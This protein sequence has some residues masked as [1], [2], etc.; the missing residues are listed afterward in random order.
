MATDVLTLPLAL[1]DS[2]PL[3]NIHFPSILRCVWTSD[4]EQVIPLG[5]M[6]FDDWFS[7]R[8]IPITYRPSVNILSQYNLCFLPSSILFLPPFYF[9]LPFAHFQFYF[10]PSLPLPY[11]APSCSCQRKTLGDRHCYLVTFFCITLPSKGG[12]LSSSLSN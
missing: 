3:S 10:Q 9:P 4:C 5:L 7:S 6:L 1:W 8:P 11:S 2:L 12:Q